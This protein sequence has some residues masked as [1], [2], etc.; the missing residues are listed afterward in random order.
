[1]IRCLRTSF[2]TLACLPGMM[3]CTPGTENAS[4]EDIAVE[5][6]P[7][8]ETPEPFKTCRD[9]LLW[10]QAHR[11]NFFGQV[12]YGPWQISVDR[13]TPAC[14]ACMEGDINTMIDQA[15]HKRVKE[16][17][18]TST[19]VLQLRPEIGDPKLND[20]DLQTALF[21]L[22]GPDTIPCSLLQKELVPSGVPYK[23]LLIG[24]EDRG[25]PGSRAIWFAPSD[26]GAGRRLDLP[27]SDLDQYFHLAGSRINDPRS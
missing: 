7:L 19:Y 1:M 2:F 27:N 22:V 5:G 13:R 20:H 8:W 10:R 14:T 11:A 26:I 18:Y 21:E 25:I 15:W 6:S 3:S 9:L 4:R 23:T 24:F 16:L 17:K 12:S